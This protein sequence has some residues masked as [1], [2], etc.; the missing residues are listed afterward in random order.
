MLV[1]EDFIDSDKKYQIDPSAINSQ[2]LSANDGKSPQG[3]CS[4]QTLGLF[5][6]RS[7]CI[8]SVYILDGSL[9]MSLLGKTYDLSDKEIQARTTALFP[10]AKQ[11]KLCRNREIVFSCNYWFSESEDCWPE[12]DIFAFVQRVTHDSDSKKRFLLIF[13]ELAAGRDITRSEFLAQLD[14]K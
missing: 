5:F 8:V 7:H 12:T 4:E 2:L 6:K 3:Y 9:K 10:F 13:K 11:F 14:K 1:L